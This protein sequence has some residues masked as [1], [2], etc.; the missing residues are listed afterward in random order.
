MQGQ[1]TEDEI[2]IRPARI[3]DIPFIQSLAVRFAAVGS[4]PWRS[5][6]QMQEFHQRSM[7]EVCTAI[8]NATDLVLLAEDPQGTRLGFLYAISSADFFTAEAQGYIS[9][10]A[11][12]AQAE[13]KGVAGALMARAEV[14][15]RE[16]GF[17][18]LALD[19]F[20]SNTRA[21]SF[22]QHLG[23]SEETLKLIKEI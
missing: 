8:T 16:R 7:Q 17:R 4:P 15:A 10:V 23:Y 22:Y 19:V 11:V 18:I 21:R 1:H 14:W 9:D 12:S 3:D 20:A 13:G 6:E 5:A 2:L